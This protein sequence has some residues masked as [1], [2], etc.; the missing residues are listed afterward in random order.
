MV[1][2]LWE[3]DVIVSA[4]DSDWG[5]VARL[6]RCSHKPGKAKLELNLNKLN[7]RG[8]AVHNVF[9]LNGLKDGWITCNATSPLGNDIPS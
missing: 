4:Q 1:R 9:V 3:F 5:G 6:H 8:P 2:R 7:I